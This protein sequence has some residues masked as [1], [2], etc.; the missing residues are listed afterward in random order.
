MAYEARINEIKELI[1]KGDTISNLVLATK[2]C[3]ALL[4][5]FE[6]MERQIEILLN[7]QKSAEMPNLFPGEES[8]YL[9]DYNNRSYQQKKRILEALT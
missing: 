1:A 6:E 9:K 4:R 8:D 5:A 3:P 2:E 7:I